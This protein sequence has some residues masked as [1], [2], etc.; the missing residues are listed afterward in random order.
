MPSQK[1]APAADLFLADCRLI[2]GVS[3]K[4][5]ERSFVTVLGGK[6]AATGLMSKA[7]RK[8][9]LPVVDC[10]GRTVMPGLID[11]HVHLV[12]AGYR[13]MDQAMRTP[14]ESAVINAVGHARQYLDSGFTAVREVGTIGNTSVALRD[15]V[16][17][18]QISGPKIVAS[19]RGI[20]PTGGATDL[21]PAQWESTGGRAVVDGVDSLRKAIRRQM[22]EGVDNIKI[23]ASG[24]EGHPNCYTWMTTMSEEEVHAAVDEAHRW[25][26]TI[27]VHAQSLDSVKFALRAG[28]D[29]IEHGTRLD[30]EAIA[31]FRKSGAFLV[32]TLCTLYSVLEMGEKMNLSQKQRDEMTVNEPLWLESVKHAYKAGVKI[33]NGGDLGNRYAHG[34]NARELEFLRDVGMRPMDVIRSATS[35]A[36]RAIQRADRFGAIKPGLDADLLVVNGDPLKDVRILQDRKRLARVYQNGLLVAGTDWKGAKPGR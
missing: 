27:A 19:G 17:S 7:P 11:C 4:P 31:L 16:A 34:T 3:D 24:V 26:R 28:A 30:D 21:L 15:A 18:G 25:G 33:A 10:D 14:V 1:R 32:P 9:R 29:T 12:Y 23:L 36:A 35:V 8:H 5:Q 13:S 2:D 22:R 6:I 20:G